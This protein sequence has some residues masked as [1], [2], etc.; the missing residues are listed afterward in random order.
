MKLPLTKK[1]DEPIPE[2]S[3]T[4][5]PFKQEKLPVDFSMDT[6]VEAPE[7]HNQNVKVKCV[8]FVGIYRDCSAF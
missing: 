2:D 4:S 6:A 8:H 7:N 5:L 1:R 3:G